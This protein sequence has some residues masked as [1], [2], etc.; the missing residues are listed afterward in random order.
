MVGLQNRIEHFPYQ[1]SGGEQQRVAFARALAN[2]P[3][4]LLVDEP[5]G[6]L[7]EKISMKLI[8]IMQNL[9]AEKKSIIVA[10]HDS[11]IVKL[12]DRKWLLEDGKLASLDE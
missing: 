1:L 6:N 7:D 10:T 2:D 9:K 11:R 3:P 4:L 8:D 5:T 12:A